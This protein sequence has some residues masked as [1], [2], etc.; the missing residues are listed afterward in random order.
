MLHYWSGQRTIYGVDTVQKF[1]ML[2]TRTRAFFRAY[3]QHTI[4][5]HVNKNWVNCRWVTQN[6]RRPNGH[7]VVVKTIIWLFGC[8]LFPHVIDRGRKLFSLLLMNLAYNWTWRKKEANNSSTFKYYGCGRR[9]ESEMR[10]DFKLDVSSAQTNLVAHERLMSN[11]KICRIYRRYTLRVKNQCSSALNGVDES[12]LVW[13]NNSETEEVSPSPVC[14]LGVYIP[15]EKPPKQRGNI[16]GEIWH[17]LESFLSFSK[18]VGGLWPK[19]W[20]DFRLGSQNQDN[21]LFPCHFRPTLAW[22]ADCRCVWRG[23]FWAATNNK[24]RK[25][26]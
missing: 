7:I 12:P 13:A 15:S 22:R 5:M 17:N 4:D 25:C 20:R 19:E 14:P 2:G 6:C 10:A 8:P 11:S 3:T 18:R 24:L 26:I 23:Y 9:G 1:I 16:S 21:I